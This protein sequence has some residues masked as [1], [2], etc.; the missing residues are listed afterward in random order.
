MPNKLYVN[1]ETSLTWTD[2]GGDYTMDLGGLAADG[3]RVGAQGDLGSGA[4][5]SLYEWRLIID[6]F[7]TAPVVN[8]AVEIWLA[9]SDGTNHD[10]DISTS[11]SAGASTDLYNCHALGAA[12][13]QTTTAANELI[14]SGTVEIVSRYVSPIVYNRTSDAL[15]STADAHKFILTPSPLELQ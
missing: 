14:V 3:V 7:D 13:V 2:T 6:G 1:Q 5:A 15:L 11:D 12:I 4:R 8:Q 10:G 9:F